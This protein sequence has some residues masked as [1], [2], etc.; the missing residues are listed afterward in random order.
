MFQCNEGTHK[1]RVHVGASATPLPQ[2]KYCRSSN[3]DLQKPLHFHIGRADPIPLNMW[4]KLLPQTELTLNLLKQSNTA[5]TISAQAHL[6]GNFDFIRM[7]LAPMGCAV[8]IH[9]ES[10]QKRTWALHSADG[11]YLGASPDHYRAQ[12]I[13]V[14]ATHTERVSELVFFKH[15]YLTNPT[16]THA[17]RVVQAARELHNTLSKKKQAWTRVP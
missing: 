4:D 7:P 15:K 10:S 14:K 9:E 12:R 13:Y 5:P 8:Q 16:V 6:F 11:Y 17:D 1:I 2:E 3:Q